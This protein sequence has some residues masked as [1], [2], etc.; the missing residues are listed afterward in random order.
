M[1]ASLAHRLDTRARFVYEED[2]S[3]DLAN[4]LKYLVQGLEGVKFC[5]VNPLANSFTVTF[6]KGS[7]PNLAR[8]ILD[9]DIKTIK[10]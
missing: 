10:D 1:R 5:K 8:F 3:F 7:L 2:L 9:L 6:E 4:N